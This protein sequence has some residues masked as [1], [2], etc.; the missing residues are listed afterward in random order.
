[1]TITRAPGRN[2]APE[3]LVYQGRKTSFLARGLKDGVEYRFV[4]VAYD[5]AGNRSAGVAVVVFA[6][7]QN[8]LLPVNGATITAPRRFAWRP[9][10]GADYYN[11]QFWQDGKSSRSG[12]SRPSSLCKGA[13]ASKGRCTSSF[14][15]PGWSMSGR[16][17]GTRRRPTTATSMSTP[18]SSSGGAEPRRAPDVLVVGRLLA[19]LPTSWRRRS[20]RSRASRA[21]SGAS[22]ATSR[23]DSLGSRL[24]FTLRAGLA[25]I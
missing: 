3:T 14:P 8:L 24:C 20:R 9:V 19:D 6:E 18:P 23:P 15:A 22:P 16:G 17:S 12:P 1:M 2:G 21:S 10:P 7:R 11:A 13:G 5:E 25:T 4:V